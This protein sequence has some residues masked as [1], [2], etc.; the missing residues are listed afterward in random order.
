MS[1]TTPDHQG[2]ACEH[3]LA[4][5]HRILK[6]MWRFDLGGRSLAFFWWICYFWRSESRGKTPLFPRK[7]FLGVLFL[8]LVYPII[9]AAVNVTGK[10][11]SLSSCQSQI[12]ID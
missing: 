2:K 3:K 6:N 11:F 1:A 7:S 9:R 12:Q 8:V 4:A 5:L 10:S